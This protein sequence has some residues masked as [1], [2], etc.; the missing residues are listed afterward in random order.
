[1]APAPQ[2]LCLAPAGPFAAR[3]YA[4]R[5]E[6]GASLLVM[7]DGF[8]RLV[9]PYGLYTDAG[10]MRACAGGRLEMLLGELREHERLSGGAGMAI[11]QADDASAVVWHF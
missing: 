4:V 8:Y 10:L 11:K 3:R 6:R 7:T 2:S 1:M 9:E 5:A